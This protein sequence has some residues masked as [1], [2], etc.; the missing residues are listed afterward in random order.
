MKFISIV[1]A[2]VA[3]VLAATMA[4]G[5]AHAQDGD[6]VVLTLTKA[7]EGVDPEPTGTEFT[8]NAPSLGGEVMIKPGGSIFIEVAP[9]LA[10]TFT[11]LEQDGWEFVSADCTGTTDV[12]VD[13]LVL[14]GT[15]QGED[16]TCT[17]VN[18]PVNPDPVSLT[19]TKQVVGTDPTPG[20]TLF[21]FTETSGGT[22]TFQRDG[23]SFSFDF[24]PPSVTV[25]ERPQIGW[26]V[27]GFT[28][29][30]AT[31]VVSSAQLQAHTI[32]AAPGATVSCTF[33]NEQ[34]APSA[35]TVVKRVEGANPTNPNFDFTIN[36]GL[37]DFVLAEDGAVQVNLNQGT[38]TLA[39]A[40]LAG[41]QVPEI[42]CGDQAP[43]NAYEITLTLDG[44]P[45][46]CVFVNTP[47]AADLLADVNC[48][49]IVNILDAFATAQYVVELRSGANGC[50]LADSMA[51]INLDAVSIGG[52]TV[53]IQDAYRVAQCAVGLP[54]PLCPAADQ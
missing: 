35:V 16:V 10:F 29:E 45:L 52:A 53:T 11:E 19:V 33:V 46:E 18:R 39:E 38:Y 44:G 42:T 50:P 40:P 27:T 25:T 51:E 5:T 26:V 37:Q 6:G 32:L 49:G 22:T 4:Y 15:V 8:F 41:W 48:D 34:E 7:V 36:N 31:Q 28:C 54:N 3:A 14:Q 17:F 20:G 12:T 21:E 1:L 13:G 47:A 9:T 43:V 23:E 24:T 2:L 30:G